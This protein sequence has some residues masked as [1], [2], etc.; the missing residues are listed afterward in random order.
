MM[1][2]TEQQPNL[3]Q[4]QPI[5]SRNESFS[6]LKLKSN[7]RIDFLTCCKNNSSSIKKL[8]PQ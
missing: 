7:S 2:D 5:L 1:H 4:A 6:N 3:D 8:V